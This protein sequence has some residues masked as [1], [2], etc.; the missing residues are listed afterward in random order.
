KGVTEIRGKGL[1]VGIELE[2]PCGELVRGALAQ[3]L[4]MNVTAG[5]VIRLLPPLVIERGEIDMIVNVVEHI[6]RE[7]LQE[8]KGS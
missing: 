8:L 2:H 3:G 4:V 7:F 1:M 6:V 5:N